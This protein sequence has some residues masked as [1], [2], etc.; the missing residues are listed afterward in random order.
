LDKIGRT[1]FTPANLSSLVIALRK[2]GLGT[3]IRNR[4]T[5]I[6]P[7]VQA[8]FLIAF[9]L[10]FA[11]KFVPYAEGVFFITSIIS[12]IGKAALNAIKKT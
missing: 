5:G 9:L 3:T 4:L 7:P 12:G 8:L 6:N 2:R 10:P 11:P 1:D